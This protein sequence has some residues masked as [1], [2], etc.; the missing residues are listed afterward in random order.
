M[1]S[2]LKCILEFRIEKLIY[3]V[4]NCRQIPE[5]NQRTAESGDLQGRQVHTTLWIIWLKH[6]FSYEE[7]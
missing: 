1:E 6:S 2:G 3:L 5:L 7:N 4:V